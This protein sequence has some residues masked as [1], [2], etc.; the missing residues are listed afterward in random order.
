MSDGAGVSSEVPGLFQTHV[1]VGRIQVLVTIELMLA[2]FLKTRKRD[3][4]HL[5]TLDLLLR[6]H[7]GP[8]PLRIISLLINLKLID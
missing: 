6:A 3:S 2:C 4:L 7:S 5:L 1:I 8:G